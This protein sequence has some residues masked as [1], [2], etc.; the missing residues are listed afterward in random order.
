MLLQNQKEL[1]LSLLR[2]TIER[3]KHACSLYGFPWPRTS[4]LPRLQCLAS[5]WA[6]FNNLW[7]AGAAAWLSD[8][9]PEVL[10]L[11]RVLDDCSEAAFVVSRPCTCEEAWTGEKSSRYTVHTAHSRIWW[12]SGPWGPSAWPLSHLVYTRL[13]VPC[14]VCGR[15]FSFVSSHHFV[16]VEL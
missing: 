16:K 4:A 6:W 3:H 2:L 8:P 13:R 5:Q 12:E 11:Y 9:S 15:S 1:G 14:L 10:N 7:V